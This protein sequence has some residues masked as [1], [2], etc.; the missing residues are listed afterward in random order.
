MEGE[1]KETPRRKKEICSFLFRCSCKE[2]SPKMLHFC[3]HLLQDS[4]KS[5]V[6]IFS[7][8]GDNQDDLIP[9]AGKGHW[10]DPDMV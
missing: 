1:L 6:D 10:N 4:F 2:I 8:F 7:W 3:L 9:A 5:V